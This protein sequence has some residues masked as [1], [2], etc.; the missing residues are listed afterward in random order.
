MKLSIIMY[1]ITND[2]PSVVNKVW[3]SQ[4]I[5][6]C[7]AHK[8][9]SKVRGCSGIH[10]HDFAG[11]GPKIIVSLS[12]CT[13]GGGGL[14]LGKFMNLSRICSVQVWLTNLRNSLSRSCKM[15]QNWNG[16]SWKRRTWDS[17]TPIRLVI[18]ILHQ[19]PVSLVTTTDNCSQSRMLLMASRSFPHFTTN[20]S[21]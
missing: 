4:M 15:K 17:T 14:W 18:A 16:W 20:Y 8:S 7:R 13:Q 1:L 3:V 12:T 10:R 5:S 11:A 19:L 21:W 2:R 6:S 9:F